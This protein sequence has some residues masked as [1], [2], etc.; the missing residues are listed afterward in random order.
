MPKPTKRK[1]KPSI[2]RSAHD[3]ERLKVLTSTNGATQREKRIQQAARRLAREL[4]RSDALLSAI[5][6]TL[7]ARA[8]RL[9]GAP[10]DER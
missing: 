5:G 9:A 6:Q 1:A 8:D 3:L 2:T 10:A 7:T 4:R